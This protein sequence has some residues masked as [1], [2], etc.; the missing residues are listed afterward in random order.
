MKKFISVLI[1]VISVF[2]LTICANAADEK[3]NVYLDGFYGTDGQK[4]NFDVPPQTINNRTMV[5]IRAI[6]EAMGATVDWDDATQTAKCVKDG[7]TV[8]MTLNSTTEYINGTPNQMDVSPVVIDGRTLAPARYVAEAFG[9][10]VSCDEMTQSVLISKDEKY[11]ISDVIDGTR[12]H[13]YNLGNTISFKFYGYDDEY[14]ICTL[15][16]K[17][18]FS[19]EDM[20]DKYGRDNYFTINDIWCL[21]GHIKLNE[22]S[23]DDSCSH[24]EMIYS[25]EVVTS[26]LKKVGG[27]QWWSSLDLPF[28]INFELYSGGE[29]D[30][31][32]AIRKD[33][34]TEGETADFFTITYRSG[35][36]YYDQK[37]IWFSLK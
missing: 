26:K 28:D 16:L 11:S 2:C 35:N 33:N 10:H 29:T 15:T 23:G 7:T 3:I 9:Y 37:T 34:L 8:E 1:A 25:S 30:C 14:G 27:C 12:A 32:I 13:P 31:Y 17:K 6:F 18:L 4:I 20:K 5:P 36:D 21:T 24:Q 22:F 19:P